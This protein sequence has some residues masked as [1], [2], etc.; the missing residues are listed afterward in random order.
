MKL[1]IVESP[2]KAKTI[3]QYLGD[4]VVVR[5]SYGHVRDL[6][7]SELGIDTEQDFAPTYIVPTKAKKNL[8]ELKKEAAK[9]DTIVLA[10]DEDREGEAIAWHLSQALDLAK[11][12]K[13]KKD[14]KVQRIVFHEITK[15]A[16]QHAIEHPR[17]LDRHLVDAQQARRVLDRLVGYKLSPVLWKRYYRGLSAG[18]VQSVATRLIVEREREIEAFK[19]E[20]Y[21]TI[22]ASLATPN[23]P[24]PIAAQLVRAQGAT[25]DKFGIPNKERADAIL[26]DLA[27]ATYTVTS[28]EKT[29]SSRMPHAPFT[30]STMQ[31]E[32][33]RR[34]RFSSK[35][36]MMFAQG[37]YE[38]GYI[39]YMRTD[40]VNLSEQSL[41]QAKEHIESSY[42]ANYY[43]RR[44]YKTKSKSAQEAHE[45]I[46]P[47]DP[48]RTPESMASSLT[49]QQLKLYDLIWRR[50]TASQMADARFDATA[51]DIA[52]GTYGFRATGSTLTFDGWLK[53]LPSKFEDNELPVVRDGEALALHELTPE[54]HFT[55]PPARYNEASLIKT[56]EKEGIGR[57][58]TYAAIISTILLRKYVEKDRSRYFHPTEIGT[59]VTDF[60]IA[61][62]PR[63]VDLKFTSGMEDELDDIAA[64]KRS[65]VPTIRAFYAPLALDIKEK[66]KEA[67]EA[68]EAEIEQT[69]KICDKCGST[70]VVKRGRFGKFIACSNFPE[71]KNILK[72]KKDSAPPEKV[73]RT[74]PDDGGELIY[75]VGRFGKFIACSNF[76]KC[77]HTEKIKKTETEE[78]PAD[79]EAA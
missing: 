59:Q 74:C 7:K 62:F 18:R 69:D 55:K 60:L 24:T 47:T 10:T 67:Q 57:P 8:S 14:L 16:I 38:A 23:S 37:L 6:P 11:L 42:G 71:C 32:A 53:V 33:N 76:P 19:P 39:T 75:R 36:T 2:T 15:S 1:V 63:I 17:E 65:W 9:A 66:M 25:L 28:V 68:K 73:G 26:N 3:S 79:A 20:E 70:M 72:E 29:Q 58:S 22:L 48:A 56:L 49:P 34:L 64:G 27:G 35:Q 52:A 51:I 54:Q 61:Q 4:D 41:L 78:A 30:T 5:S 13:K 45:A 77:K 43:F 21:W 31:Q 46:R 50:F 12:Q 40:S 44:K